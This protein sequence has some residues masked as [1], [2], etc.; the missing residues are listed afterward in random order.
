M[1]ALDRIN[2]V[3]ATLGHRWGWWLNIS[4]AVV[5]QSQQVQVNVIPFAGLSIVQKEPI[6]S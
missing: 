1:P 6:S 5:P 4:L 3:Q 2:P